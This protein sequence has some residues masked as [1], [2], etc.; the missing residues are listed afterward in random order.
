MLYLAKLIAPLLSARTMIG[1][2]P[3]TISGQMSWP[4]S[5]ETLPSKL[6]RTVP[7]ILI[8]SLRLMPL[9]AAWKIS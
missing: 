3:G 4:G 8:L 6:R 7:Y 5:E 2:G 9:T 1:I